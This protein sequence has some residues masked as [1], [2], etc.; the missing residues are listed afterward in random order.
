M[1]RPAFGRAINWLADHGD[2]TIG[3]GTASQS[4]EISELMVEDVRNR[5]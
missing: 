4:R 2:W 3:T 5:I 1:G